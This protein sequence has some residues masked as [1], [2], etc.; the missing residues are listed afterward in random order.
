MV[1]PVEVFQD[2]E[3]KAFADALMAA[4]PTE[5]WP[6][7]QVSGGDSVPSLVNKYYN[8]DKS[9]G[10]SVYRTLSKT[11]IG[12]VAQENDVPEGSLR[13]RKGQTLRLPPFIVRPK[14][15]GA[16]A[17]LFQ[18]LDVS[19]GHLGLLDLRS[20]SKK[21][22][23]ECT[24]RS[25]PLP[26]TSPDAALRRRQAGSVV[27]VVTPDQRADL[28]AKAPANLRA[29]LSIN[30]LATLTA[31]TDPLSDVKTIGY[32]PVAPPLVEPGSCRNLALDTAGHLL[33]VDVF[34]EKPCSHGDRVVDVV[35]QVLNVCGAPGLIPNVLRLPLAIDFD[36]VKNFN[37]DACQFASRDPL[38]AR[39]CDF[40]EDL[41]KNV[42]DS[43]AAS[44]ATHIR[45]REIPAFALQAIYWAAARP[46]AGVDVVN[47]SL[48]IDLSSET[49]IVPENVQGST[50]TSLVLASGNNDETIEN[51]DDG[52]LLRQ[53]QR[54]FFELRSA[55]PLLLAGAVRPTAT[56]FGI[57]S[58]RSD[59]VT[60]VAPGV[61]YG[62]SGSCIKPDVSGTS[63]AAPA[64][65]AQLFVAKAVWRGKSLAISGMGARERLLLAGRIE[66]TL[67]GRYGSGGIPVLS[68][69]VGLTSPVLVKPSGELEHFEL[70][71]VS[72]GAR[73]VLGPT[74]VHAI[75]T[76]A[77]M[78]RCV[79]GI[80]RIGNTTY[81]MFKDDLRWMATNS[82]VVDMAVD[83]A[84]R[85]YSVKDDLNAKRLEA[86]L[87][88]TIQ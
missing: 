30:P 23:L 11:I 58:A 59:G 86:I 19:N 14:T 84:G 48:W 78:D 75:C 41:G 31:N 53:P 46:S 44:L 3:T 69:L 39:L 45:N 73:V 6:T 61:G 43:F 13:I 83:V 38:L 29:I 74:E 76:A 42:R 28:I 9:Y 27:V 82:A 49:A 40:I 64:I 87:I 21:R 47:T 63:F 88:P 79:K 26:S 17:D 65:A 16:R 10:D 80:Q 33:I 32:V 71:H 56:S 4:V 2:P 36:S 8:F 5:Q 52:R 67:A 81:L 34:A 24:E 68:R 70:A 15:Q 60:T 51:M 22:P 57:Y 12:R 77:S 66:P 55:K 54:A 20:C 85:R 72:A 62:F 1:V 7:V 35:K 18:V 25:A 50:G 37:D